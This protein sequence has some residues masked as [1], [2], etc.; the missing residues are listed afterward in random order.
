MQSDSDDNRVDTGSEIPSCVDWKEKQKYV[1]THSIDLSAEDREGDSGAE[2]GEEGTHHTTD[3]G[4]DK[5][6]QKDKEKWK[7]KKEEKIGNCLSESD[8][9]LDR[10]EGDRWY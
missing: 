4:K 3:T 10:E 9:G 7:G 1:R 2:G 6:S 8:M 5:D